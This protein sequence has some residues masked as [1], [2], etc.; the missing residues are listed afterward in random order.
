[1]AFFIWCHKTSI[2]S[3][4]DLK[5]VWINRDSIIEKHLLKLNNAIVITV[6]TYNC[7]TNNDEK[8]LDSFHRKKDEVW[9]HQGIPPHHFQFWIVKEAH[10]SILWFNIQIPWEL[11]ERILWLS[12][13]TPSHKS[14][15]FYFKQINA[16]HFRERTT[17]VY[18]MENDIK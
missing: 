7:M 2:A 6:L 15:L 12:V 14:V 16:T 17:V 11:F 8:K 1:M 13:Q 10:A 18:K 3:M 9:Y 5:M 4:N